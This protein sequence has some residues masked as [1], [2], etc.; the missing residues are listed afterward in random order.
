MRYVIARRFKLAFPE[1][2]G[3]QHVLYLNLIH[4][5]RAV[6]NSD[7]DLSA[8]GAIHVFSHRPRVKLYKIDYN[9]KDNTVSGNFGENG[10]GYIGLSPFSL[11]RIDFALKQ[12]NEWLDIHKIKTIEL[13]F[14]GRYLGPGR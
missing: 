13:S 2:E 9:D 6:L 11:W 1:L 8:Q 12:G 3:S 14:E 4:S 10:Q 5:G 7:T